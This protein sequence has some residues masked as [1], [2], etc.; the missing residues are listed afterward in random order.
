MQRD[1]INR[2]LI[3]WVDLEMTGLDPENDSILEIASIV[4]DADLELIEEGPE[5]VIQHTANEFDLM[6]RW[7]QRQHTKSGLWEKAL[8]STISIEEAESEFLA[9]IK[10]F[11]T[12]KERAMLAGNSIWQDRRFMINYM[13]R[14]EDYLHYRMIDVSSLKILTKNWYPKVEIPKKKENHRAMDDIKESI[15]ELKFYRDYIFRS[16]DD[17]KR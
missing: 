13:P 3:L 8:N 7:N 17:V 11:Y 5:F 6:D 14:L 1:Q 4:T 2:Q 12:K 16:R 10:K 15:E 9:F